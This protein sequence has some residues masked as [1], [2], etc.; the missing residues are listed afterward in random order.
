M[1]AGR[2]LVAKFVLKLEDR[3]SA[4]LD[5]LT[6]RL[7]GLGDMGRRIGVLGGALAALSMVGPIQQAAAYD[8]VLR[9]NAIT[10]GR[11]G[12]AVEAMV[13]RQSA[14]YQKLAL[15]TG[16]R[17]LDVAN[18]AGAMFA[19]GFDPARID[20]LL[21]VVARVAQAAGAE[22]GDMAQ[23]VIALNQSLKIKPEDMAGALAALA[24]AGKEGQF[25]LKAMARE[26]QALLPQAV[27]L[28]ME[29]REAVNSIA[30]ALQ[31]ARKG[32]ATESEAA[33]N[34]SDFMGKLVSPDVK[35]NFADMGV[36]IMAVLADATKR[37]LNPIEVGLQQVLMLT[38]GKLGQIVELF[39]DKQARG[40]ILPF[41]QDQEMKRGAD[42]KNTLVG[43]GNYQRIR[44]LAAKAGTGVIDDDF[45]SRMAGIA[46]KLTKTEEIIGQ[47]G[48]R[49]GTGFAQNLDPVNEA[50]STLLGW[51]ERIDQASPGLIGQVLGWTGAIIGL[52]AAFGLLSPLFGVIGAGFA[53]LTSPVT[54]AIGAIALAAYLMVTPWEEVEATFTALWGRIKGLFSDFASWVDGWTGGAVT[55]TIGRLTAAWSGLRDF[56]AGLWDGVKQTFDAV[57]GPILAV[58]A[59]VEQVRD[60]I[61]GAPQVAATPAERNGRMGARGAAEG[62][63]GKD[64]AAAV[65]GEITV[66]AEPGT[67]ATVTDPGNRAAPVVQDRGQVLGRP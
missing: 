6:A 14:A 49:I 39:G 42:G 13:A 24:V 62:F 64:G 41:M 44:D 19:A 25:E 37:G 48:V 55:A 2:D 67:S 33:N 22:M 10:A 4:G 29:G 31:I 50:L 47:I 23:T 57:F 46:A 38:K 15:E 17:S 53:L 61:A 65:S 32:A 8:Q 5:R 9:G 18:A 66:R 1:A 56:F 34:L 7:R 20:A 30:A 3:L 43:P 52:A 54:L 59:R 28:G 60:R 58:I 11:T 35:K 16:Q 45:A 40:L 36:D 26:F 51:I 63:Y 21:P 27:A 12:A